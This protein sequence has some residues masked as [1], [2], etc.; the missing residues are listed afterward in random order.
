MEGGLAQFWDGSD[1][2]GRA[3]A[4]LLFAMSVAS[5]IAIL[6]K[7]FTLRR[8]ARDGCSGPDRR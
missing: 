7:G 6:W 5:W 2:I 1:A 8:A 3:V 4:L